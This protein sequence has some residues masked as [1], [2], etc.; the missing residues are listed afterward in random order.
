MVAILFTLCFLVVFLMTKS[1]QYFSKY[2]STILYV[3]LVALG[4]PLVCRG[5]MVWSFNDWGHFTDKANELMQAVILFPSITVLFL[6]FL[7]QRIW[8]R[9]LYFLG[10]FSIFAVMELYMIARN[11]I[12]YQHG[13][14]YGWS[15]FIDF[16]LFALLWIH[17]KSW[18]TALI[19]SLCILIFLVIVFRVPV[20]G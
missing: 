16:C 2:Y 20:T 8:T 10:F 6:R 11:E 7:P 13:W 1:Y 9:A 15:L 19:L 4:Y 12:F 14:N 5:Y 3:S 18:N 17:A